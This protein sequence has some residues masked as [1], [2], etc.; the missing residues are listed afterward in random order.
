VLTKLASPVRFLFLVSNLAH[1]PPSHD[2][3]LAPTRPMLARRPRCAGCNGHALREVPFLDLTPVDR[4]R[5]FPESCCKPIRNSDLRLRL[6]QS[7]P[8]CR[9]CARVSAISRS[10][11]LWSLVPAVSA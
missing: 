5:R 10:A 4:R 3:L 2:G 7:G 11:T 1:G 9:P 6:G 8:G